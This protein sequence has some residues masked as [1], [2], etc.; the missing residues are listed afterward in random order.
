MHWHWRCTGLVVSKGYPLEQH[1]VITSD[2]YKL[3][4]FRIPHGRTPNSKPGPPVLLVHGIF[5]CSAQWVWKP[6]EES[7]AFLLADAGDKQGLG[8]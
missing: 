1:T 3:A 8:L 6:A 5:L 7:L 4:T 2:G